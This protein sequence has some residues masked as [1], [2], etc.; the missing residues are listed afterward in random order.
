MRYHSRLRLRGRRQSIE[1]VSTAWRRSKRPIDTAVAG[2]GSAACLDS[3][4]MSRK[5]ILQ[6]AIREG[7]AEAHGVRV[8][9][10]FTHEAPD[11]VPNVKA[12]PKFPF[13]T[14]DRATH[15]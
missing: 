1:G 6:F 10:V 3:I 11:V 2:C 5:A 8:I 4:A 7:C 13:H 12:A 14:N 9:W 15:V